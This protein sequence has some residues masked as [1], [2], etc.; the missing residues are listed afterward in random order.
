MSELAQKLAD[1]VNQ[2]SEPMRSL[3]KRRIA[4]DTLSTGIREIASRFNLTEEQSKDYEWETLFIIAQANDIQNFKDDLI[5]E[6]GLNYETAVRVA[7]AFTT[8]ILVPLQAELES[9]RAATQTT[10]QEPPP[11]PQKTVLYEDEYVRITPTQLVKGSTTY[12]AS[13]IASVM[14]PSKLSVFDDFGGFAINGALLIAGVVGILSFSPGWMITGLIGGAIGFFN[15]KGIINSK[16][17]VTVELANGEK[18]RIERHKK[19]EID[20]IYSALSKII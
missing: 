11:P 3:I 14:T 4:D 20:A 10:N 2:L 9:L 12:S 15:V 13:K 1:D 5:A 8:E 6:V 16:W 18:V 17:W 7:R 19:D